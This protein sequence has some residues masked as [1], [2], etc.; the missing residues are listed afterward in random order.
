MKH[1]IYFIMMLALLLSTAQ[2]SEEPIEFHEYYGHG[3][4]SIAPEDTSETN[5]NLL[6]DWENCKTV[7]LNE[8]APNGENLVVTLPWRNG[9]NTSLNSNF[10][11]DIKAADGWSMLF[12]TFCKSNHDV[13]LS[14]MCFY[15][16]FTGFL[17]VFYYSR[18]KDTGTSTIWNL[19]SAD[20]STP[21]S[22]FADLEYFSQPIE[23]E[24]TY[25]VWSATADNM[26]MNGPTGLTSGWN[27]FEFRIGEYHPTIPKENLVIRAFNTAYMNIKID[28]VTESTTNGTITT[29][30]S[31]STSG[32]KIVGA[33]A[34]VGGSKAKNLVDSFATKHLDKSFLGINF[35][36]IINSVAKNDY[37]SAFKSGLGCIFKGLFK[38]E[39][40][41][42]EVKLQTNGTLTLQ[43]SAQYD[44]T[45][46]VNPLE[47]DLDSVLSNSTGISALGV[48]NLK[49]K[50]TMYYDRY[51]KY[52]SNS[53]ITKDNLKDELLDFTGFVTFPN[54]FINPNNIEVVFNPAIKDYVKHFS[55]EV[56]MI[57]VEGGNRVIYNKGKRIIKLNTLNE[58]KIDKDRNIKVYGIGSW[59]Y[60]LSGSIYGYPDGAINESTQYYVDWGEN[61]EG[62]RAAVI[63][64]SFDID[65]RG[66]Q[67]SFAET[68]VYDVDY[69]PYSTSMIEQE[70]NTPPHTFIINQKEYRVFGFQLPTV[71]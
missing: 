17:K 53:V 58:I 4:R 44:L 71:Y 59:K 32:G 63:T 48:W 30:N 39:P 43:G 18:T 26:I 68:R 8:T 1:F 16:K 66:K 15:N 19:S 27:G 10:C 29:T 67:M 33:V 56:G 62:N 24:K 70:V 38:K 12:H 20:S 28:G 41:V 65:Y 2:C 25:S 60:D 52:E 5:P 64:L 40:T 47:F 36:D 45:S 61:V 42:Q 51:T 22:L 6:T 69:K 34:N 37:I 3:S 35:K 9:A 46:S 57:D 11:N 55:V 14:Y 31:T 49:K 13:D 50:P 23:G 21:Q 54:T 7:K